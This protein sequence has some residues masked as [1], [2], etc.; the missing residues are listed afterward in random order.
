MSEKYINKSTFFPNEGLV[1]VQYYEEAKKQIGKFKCGDKE[2][3]NDTVVM[4]FLLDETEQF[5]AASEEYNKDD[6]KY[7]IYKAYDY[8]S[9]WCSPKIICK[10]GETHDV[11][12]NIPI[13]IQ[14]QDIIKHRSNEVIKIMKP[15]GI[16]D[17]QG[18]MIT[19]FNHFNFEKYEEEE[20]ET[21]PTEEDL[22]DLAK[23]LLA[24]GRR[25][26]GTRYG[27]NPVKY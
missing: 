1:I 4:H 9:Y 6:N 10:C 23:Y 16:P 13:A 19:F 22:Q 14:V 24:H 27:S 20:E 18:E 7:I 15:S 17:L 25:V 21:E 8:H 11:K 5:V 2:I 3:S 12:S 26:R